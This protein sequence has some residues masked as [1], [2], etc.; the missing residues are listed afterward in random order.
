MHCVVVAIERRPGESFGLAAF[1]LDYSVDLEAFMDLVGY[2]VVSNSGWPPFDSGQHLYDLGED[3]N[4][5]GRKGH[6]RGEIRNGEQ[7][8]NKIKYCFLS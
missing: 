3:Q 5:E 7:M 2:A 8:A 1:F 6:N 4:V